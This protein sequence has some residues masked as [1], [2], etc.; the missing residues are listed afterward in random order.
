MYQNKRIRISNLIKQL[1]KSKE[2]E[3]DLFVYFVSSYDWAM[4]I[5]CMTAEE[6]PGWDGAPKE[7]ALY[8]C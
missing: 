4:P 3:G 8:L 2:K 1:E 7:R 5:T 6:N